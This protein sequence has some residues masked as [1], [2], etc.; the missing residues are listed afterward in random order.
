M[1]AFDPAT[2]RVTRAGRLPEATTHAAAA[3]V[4]GTAYVIGG[5][6][7]AADTPTDAI[8]AVDLRR[9]RV[10]PAGTAAAALSDAAAV[11]LG[12]RVLVIGGR[13]PS[14]TTDSVFRLRVAEGAGPKRQVASNVYAADGAGM[15]DGPARHALDR[16]YVPN[17]Q[18]NT[19]DVIDPRTF[20]VVRHFAVGALPQHVTPSWD[21]RW[22]Y[23]LNDVGQHRSPASTRR[24]ESRTARSRSRIRTTSTSRPTGTTR[25]SSPSACTGSTSAT[26]TRSS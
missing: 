16:V 19:V 9:R 20:K 15:L 2:R 10:R 18:S 7:A 4:G 3:T 8:E 13:G 6:G 23:V 5:R 11:T 22:L 1:Y 17:S 25:S 24:P 26:R 14:G 21:L 12:H